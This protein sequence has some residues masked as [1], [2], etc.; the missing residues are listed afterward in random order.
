MRLETATEAELG[1]RARAGDVE[2]LAALLER[3]RPSL[4]ATAIGLLANRADAL[5]ALQDTYLT[6]M[7]RVGDLR[8]PAAAR[9]WL[10]AVLRS[11]CLMR[12]RR[13]REVPV[14]RVELPGAVPG[15][16]E[17]LENHVMRDWLW[18]ALDT[19][20]ADERVTVILRY[21]TRCASYEAIAR[22]LGIPI[23]TVRSRLNRARTRLAEVLMRSIA[24][25]AINH[26][27]VEVEQRDRWEDFYR[28]LHERP[29]PRTYRALFA[30]DVDVRDRHGHWV[31]V[32]AW[33]A[34]EREA[35]TLGVRAKIVDLLAARSLLVLEIDF[36]NPPD[37]P[38][39]CPP[40]ATFVHQ[41]EDGRSRQVRIHY[42]IE[43]STPIAT[44]ENTT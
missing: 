43:R 27:E 3:C 18:G 6:A 25:T 36:T 42:P 10:H 8:D 7:A 12:V 13:R 29:A 1:S 5:D 44:Q 4:Y 21:F 9:A 39:H 17:T 15:P 32:K 19:L 33:S 20:P 28:T 40:Q 35:I 23:G 11:M 16:E 41:L 38:D 2:A 22:V 14:A 24:G 31:G 37:W 34:E 30:T 26:A